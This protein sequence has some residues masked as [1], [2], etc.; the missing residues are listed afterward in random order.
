[1]TVGP[2]VLGLKRVRIRGV[3][4]GKRPIGQCRHIAPGERL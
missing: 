4:P 2:R 3:A 1:M